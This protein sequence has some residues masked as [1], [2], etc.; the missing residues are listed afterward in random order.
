[1]KDYKDRKKQKSKEQAGWSSGIISFEKAYNQGSC[2]IFAWWK[3]SDCIITQ[4]KKFAL[5]V[6]RETLFFVKILGSVSCET[7][8]LPKI[9]VRKAILWVKSEKNRVNCDIFVNSERFAKKHLII[10]TECDTIMLQYY[11]YYRAKQ[12]K[13]YKESKFE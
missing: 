10:L 5:N 3:H 2:W 13:Q 6:S 9:M 7:L 11:A 8:F 12:L 1:M 4:I